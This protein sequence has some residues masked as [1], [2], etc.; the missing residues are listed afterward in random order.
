MKKENAVTCALLRAKSTIASLNNSKKQNEIIRDN[1][2]STI[3]DISICESNLI[4]Y[5][6]T[7]MMLFGNYKSNKKIPELIKKE[8]LAL[9]EWREF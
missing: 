5:A 7:K 9:P 1:P 6:A 2:N 8:I 4:V 3:S